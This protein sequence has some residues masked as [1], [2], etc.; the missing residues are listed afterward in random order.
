MGFTRQRPVQP[1]VCWKHPRD[2]PGAGRRRCQGQRVFSVT[3]F[4]INAKNSIL[5][6]S[7][8]SKGPTSPSC[9]QGGF[10]RRD[11]I[12][13]KPSLSRNTLCLPSKGMILG[14]VGDLAGLLQLIKARQCLSSVSF[15]C[16]C[17]LAVPAAGCPNPAGSLDASGSPL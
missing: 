6:E 7:K 5:M 16:P 17:A 8:E 12:K 3:S 13:G 2:A 11:Y 1:P 10:W 9:C 4:H 14:D 15:W